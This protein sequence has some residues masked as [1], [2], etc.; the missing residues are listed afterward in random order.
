MTEAEGN[1]LIKELAEYSVPELCDGM[2]VFRTMDPGIRHMAGR[3]K[4]L[5]QAFTIEVPAGEGGFVADAL[6]HVKPGEVLV[7]AGQ[8]QIRSSYWGDHRSL[9]AAKLGAEAVIIDGA[10]RDIDGC[11]AVGFPVFARAVTPGTALKTGAGRYGIPV[12]CGGIVIRPG[13]I[14]AGDRNGICAFP[15]KEAAGIL[16]KTRIKVAGQKY[17]VSEM[18]RTGTII[19]KVIKHNIEMKAGG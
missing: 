12:S 9:C 16:A 3:S 11:E 14:I 8:G 15:I 18:E 10:F 17:T 19:T 6:M 2:E 7:I 5:G 4:I 1:R 13:D